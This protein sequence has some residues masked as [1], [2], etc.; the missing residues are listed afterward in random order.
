MTLKNHLPGLHYHQNHM[1][2]AVKNSIKTGPDAPSK[3]GPFKRRRRHTVYTVMTSPYI[4]I[5]TRKLTSLAAPTTTK[6]A[7]NVGD[8]LATR[9]LHFDLAAI[10]KTTNHSHACMQRKLSSE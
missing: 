4:K 3:H 9:K 2:N 7:I 8:Q 6:E 1:M 10:V 5:L